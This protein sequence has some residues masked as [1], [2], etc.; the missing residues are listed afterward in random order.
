M[1]KDTSPETLTRTCTTPR[2]SSQPLPIESDLVDGTYRTACQAPQ[3]SRQQP[4][5]IDTAEQSGSETTS[6]NFERPRQ[7]NERRGVERSAREVIDGRRA[8]ATG[9][10]ARVLLHLH[11]PRNRPERSEHSTHT[12]CN[13]QRDIRRCLRWRSHYSSRL[14]SSLIIVSAWPIT[15]NGPNDV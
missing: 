10:H 11:L 9:S 15:S 14:S 5:R 7:A 13:T 6:M 4:R 8:D 3:P 2:T 12:G 1:W